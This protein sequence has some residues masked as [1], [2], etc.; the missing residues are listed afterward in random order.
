MSAGA[1]E[2]GGL[3]P[4][5][6]GR[7]RPAPAPASPADTITKAVGNAARFWRRDRG[8]S[9]AIHY[10]GLAALKG[11]G[12]R[13]GPHSIPYR[14]LG[15][16]P[17]AKT[18]RLPHGT[19]KVRAQ[20]PEFKRDEDKLLASLDGRGLGELVRVKREPDWQ[21]VKPLV[22][23]TESGAVVWTETGELVEGVRAE[24]RP[25][26]FTVETD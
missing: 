3:F 6:G 24:V 21:K 19:L 10:T 11:Q 22:T 25:P 2:P 26:K 9:G 18:A 14:Y 8:P 16:D 13:A 1:G 5:R 20:Q 15:P 7:E 17:K 23:A 12:V 4:E